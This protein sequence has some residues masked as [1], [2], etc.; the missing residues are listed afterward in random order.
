M[1]TMK[2]L[3]SLS[4]GLLAIGLLSACQ[5]KTEKPKDPDTV[6]DANPSKAVDAYTG[7]TQGTDNFKDL[8]EGFS[9]DGAWLNA[10]TKDINAKGKTLEV[11]GLFSGDSKILRELAL[12]KSGADHKPEQ[13]YTLTV[14]KIVVNSPFFTISQGTV[15][16][17]VY[18]NTQGFG[19]E[20]TGKIDGNLIFATDE[21]KVEFSNHP[22][23]AKQVTGKIT[24]EG[25]TKQVIKPNT[26]AIKIAS[27][28]GKVTYQTIP[29]V[30][31]GGTT[32]EDNNFDTIQHA[33]SPD[34]TW[35]AA[36]S[37]DVDASGKT[38]VVDGLFLNRQ[39]EINRKIALFLQDAMHKILKTF[40][41]TV[42]KMVVKSPYM[43]ISNGTIK[44]DVYVTK[45]APGFQAQNGNLVDGTA[46]RAKI[47]GNLYFETQELLDAYNA[48]ADDL[49]LTVTGHTAVKAYTE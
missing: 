6:L 18:V 5:Q 15:K 20:G 16:G 33:L 4:V 22:E 2:L 19:F 36:I 17:D 28:G 26:S 30:F 7:A 49:K 34:G 43:I 25:N 41:L 38:L 37:G 12:Y 21:L 24:S 23:W 9:K 10:V 39:S 1:K 45:D 44:G 31:T 46:N 32:G 29:D 14:D 35:M 40:T 8:Q 42:D 48:Q 3:S 27:V 11:A 13:T 47:D